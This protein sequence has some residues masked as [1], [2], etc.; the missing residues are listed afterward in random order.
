MLSK[1]NSHKR[2]KPIAV[3]IL[4]A[5]CTLQAWANVEK[6][7]PRL[8]YIRNHSFTTLLQISINDTVPITKPAN[9]NTKE[10]LK[11]QE[12]SV[13]QAKQTAKDA[14]KDVPVQEAI[15]PIKEVPKAR[16]QNKPVVVQGPNIPVKVPRIKTPKV[17]IKKIKL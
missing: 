17:V 12:P 11:K 15:K 4:L 14:A 1:L 10:E 16:R 6:P 9:P 3:F 13:G 5:I 8:R 2:A 7:Q